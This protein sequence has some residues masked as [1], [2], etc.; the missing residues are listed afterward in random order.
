M[1]YM[2]IA[3]RIRLAAV[4]QDN[5]RAT[6]DFIRENLQV[7][8]KLPIIHIQL[9]KL[10]FAALCMLGEEKQDDDEDVNY[11]IEQLE[12]ERMALV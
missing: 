10:A 7:S 8:F 3:N 2:E 1:N 6:V 5:S 9:G 4:N 12:S 11:L